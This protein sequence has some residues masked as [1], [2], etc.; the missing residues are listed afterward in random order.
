MEQ[1]ASK[2]RLCH[3]LT[4]NNNHMQGDGEVHTEGA[5]QQQVRDSDSSC[6]FLGPSR[7]QQP[8][9]YSVFSFC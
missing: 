2:F 1:L 6:K 3:N 8:A 4:T 7:S 9:T 5:N